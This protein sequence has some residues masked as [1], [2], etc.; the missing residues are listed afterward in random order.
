[1]MRKTL[2][3]LAAAAAFAAWA[4]GALAHHSAAMFDFTKSVQVKGV[5]KEFTAMNPHLRLLLVV[6]DAKGPHD[7]AF[8][9]HSLNNMYRGGWRPN[10]VKVGDQITI[11]IAPERDG[12]P[13]GYVTSIVTEGGEKLG[14]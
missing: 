7:I 5:V 3:A 1:M 10:K 6:T 4:P 11:N 9:G 2:A 13:G 14:M 8:E 12:S